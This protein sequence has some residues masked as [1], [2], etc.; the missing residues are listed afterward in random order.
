MSL[1]HSLTHIQS[2]R[3][4][5][6]LKLFVHA[7]CLGTHS[8]EELNMY[9][10]LERGSKKHPGYDAV[11]SV[12]DSFVI[13]GP[14]GKHR[15]IVHHPLW[16]S[17]LAFLHRN[18]IRKLPVPVLAFTLQ[19]LFAAL[20]YLHTECKTI[21]TGECR[22]R[23]QVCL[24]ILLTD[25]IS[26]QISRRITSCLCRRR[27]GLPGFRTTRA[28]GSMSEKSRGPTNRLRFQDTQNP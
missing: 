19:R 7:S 15:C 11:R 23:Y 26:P 6:V 4:H 5:V 9:K 22:D 28:S 18:P 13:D 1:L 17:L 21:H 20:D 24:H 12:L 25:E 8:D 16:E 27:F 10:R 2:H 3:R 14:D